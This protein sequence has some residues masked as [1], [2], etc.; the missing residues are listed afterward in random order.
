M[1]ISLLDYIKKLEARIIKLEAVV[2][3]LEG[4]NV[5]TSNCLYEIYN[6]I[7]SLRNIKYTDETFT[8]G[9]K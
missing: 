4:E 9:E 1:D 7:D 3:N 5:E 6:D 2:K 8:L